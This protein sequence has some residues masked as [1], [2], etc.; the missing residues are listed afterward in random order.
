MRTYSAHSSIT[1]LDA[2]VPLGRLTVHARLGI[3]VLTLMLTPQVH[4]DELAER[5]IRDAEITE[6]NGTL[7]LVVPPR[8]DIS[9]G[10]GGANIAG[11]VNM[12]APTAGAVDAE[13]TVPAHLHANLAS[14]DGSITTDGALGEVTAHT[15][16]G[17]ITIADATD[18]TVGIANGAI[19]AGRVARVRARSNNGN[20]HVDT[21]TDHAVLDTTNGN[22]TVSRA[23]TDRLSA[24][25]VNGNVEVTQATGVTLP[26]SAGHTMNG[27]VHVR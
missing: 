19:T 26:A 13:L 3:E 17:D 21:V 1:A 5:A 20:A 25:T 8:G 14:M 2:T 24:H 27:R 10:A 23:E 7:R 11:A 6:H 16:N 12:V 22:I 4:G 18:L 9:G 15:N